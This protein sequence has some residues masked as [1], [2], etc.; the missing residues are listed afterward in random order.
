[1]R[2]N[3]VVGR[4]LLA[5]IS[6]ASTGPG[7]NAA[8][9]TGV[10]ASHT[11]LCDKIF[12]KKGARISFTEEFRSLWQRTYHRTRKNK[13]KASRMHNTFEQRGG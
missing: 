12:V 10:W 1:M 2:I 11:E 13:G 9:L 6:L 7:L 8:D 4:A 5:C 3:P